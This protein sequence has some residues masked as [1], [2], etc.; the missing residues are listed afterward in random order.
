[1]KYLIMVIGLV[2]TL[3]PVFTTA[4][5]KKQILSE[6]SA[7]RVT[8]AGS[9]GSLWSED[10]QDGFLFGD[11]KAHNVGDVVTVRIV[12]S[13]RGN[14]NASTKT[15]KD[16]SLSTS[17]SAFFGMSPDKLSQG[18][19]GAETS[20]KHDGSGSTSRSSDLTAMLTAKVIDRLPNGNLVIDGRREVIVN[21]ETQHISLSGII[22]PED[23]GPSN[24]VLS[25]YISDA[26]IIYTG[27]GVIGDKQKVGWFIRIMDAVWPF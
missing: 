16:S 20:E 9:D 19:V 23:I 27:E 10:R 14:K 17:I 5:D 13:S 22:R 2:L 12:E 24:M 25:T 15:E 11:L 26:K 3:S 1:M 21:N 8:K 18:G 6:G 4:E 7:E